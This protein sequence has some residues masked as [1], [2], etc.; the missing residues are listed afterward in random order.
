VEDR[1]KKRRYTW[2]P[3]KPDQRDHVFKAK[4][5]GL[6]RSI[7]LRPHCSP[8]EDQRNLGACTANAIVGG[9]EF[10]EPPAA[11]IDLSRLFVYY[12]ER[13][14]EGTVGTDAGAEIRDGVKACANVGVCAES[15]WPYKISRFRNK[16]TK[17]AYADAA[18]RKISE[19]QRV[20]D[21]VALRT[22]LAGGI[23]VVFGFS[24]YESF[25][26]DAVAR[27]GI[28][29]MPGP[30]EKMLGGHAVLAVGYDDGAKT[31]IV[32]NSWGVGWAAAG[33]CFMPYAYVADRN[34][35]DDFWVIRK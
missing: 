26:S 2:R 33:Y 14:I 24:V 31:V 17:A 15:L 29:P 30:K 8:V 20:T 4:W 27:T 21:L 11:R 25:E 5:W 1:L 16:P 9:L 22:A 23:P 34:L 6:P 19:Y 3:D 13:V 12:Q 35:S 18:T 7:D 10:L 28:V 32:R